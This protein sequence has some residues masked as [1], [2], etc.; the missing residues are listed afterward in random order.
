MFL[1][2]FFYEGLS[3]NSKLLA[4]IKSKVVHLASSAN[5]LATVQT[6]AQAVLQAGWSVL[7]PTPNGRARTLSTLLLNSG[8]NIIFN[9]PEQF[10][11]TSNVTDNPYMFYKITFSL[12]LHS[13]NYRYG[14]ENV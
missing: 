13:V 12:L 4:S 10:L 7:L 1:T 5:I 6:A 8:K 3:P 9:H 14:I 11:K 2:L